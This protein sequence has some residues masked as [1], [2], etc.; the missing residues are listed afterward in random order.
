ML[1]AILEATDGWMSPKGEF[2]PC[3]LYERINGGSFSAHGTTALEIVHE[4]YPYEDIDES[5]SE[6]T[7]VAQNILLHHGWMRV[8]IE[9]IMVNKATEWQLQALE[10]MLAMPDKYDGFCRDSARMLLDS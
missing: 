6:P 4:L 8:D 3:Y 5:E 7:I 10:K 2:Y 1:Q 9:S